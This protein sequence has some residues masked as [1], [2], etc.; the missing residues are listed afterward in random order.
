MT[1]CKGVKDCSCHGR[2]VKERFEEFVPVLKEMVE[3]DPKRRL[4]I[5]KKLPPCFVTLI[6]ETS[7]NILKGN[8]KLPDSHYDSLRPHKQML[9]SMCRPRDTFKKKKEYLLKKKGGFLAALAP[10]I[11]SALSGFAGQTLARTFV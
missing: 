8:L 9:V 3:A 10:I 2:S 6:C 11:L 5:M 7:L 1:R 4:K